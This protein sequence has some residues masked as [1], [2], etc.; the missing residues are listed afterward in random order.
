MSRSERRVHSENVPSSQGTSYDR[1]RRDRQGYRDKESTRDRPYRERE[2]NRSHTSNGRES[3]NEPAWNKS[4]RPPTSHSYHQSP[5]SER[6]KI[7]KHSFS[8][9]CSRFCSR[10]GVLQFA[11]ITS[12]VLVLICVVSSY[13]VL[14][15]YTSGAGFNVFSIDSAYSPFQGTELQQVRDM[16]MQYTQLRAPGVYGGVGFSLLVCALTLVFLIVGSKPL[17]S[18]SLRILFAEMIFEILAFVGYIT[19]VGLYLYFVKQV[20]TT[21]ICKTRERLYA[22]RGYTWMNC[23]IQGGDAGVSLFGVIAACLYL[24]SAILC[25]L[26]IRTVREFRKLHPHC[27][28]KSQLHSQ[29][30]PNITKD[31]LEMTQFHPS[32]LV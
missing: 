31:N 29:N 4:S 12:G 11:E 10:R 22:G 5:P 24:P 32:T 26:H 14:M 2:Q 17:Y 21:D 23:E 8:D 16:D 19:A 20:N 27:R 15:G 6:A 18:V 9:K 7:E 30:E 3:L 28:Y 25:W 13:A 1:P